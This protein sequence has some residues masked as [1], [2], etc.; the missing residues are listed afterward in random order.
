MKYV[1]FAFAWGMSCAG[2]SADGG[3]GLYLET[4]GVVVF[5]AENTASD[6][7]SWVKKTELEGFNGSGY[8]E[9]T[10]NQP[11][12]GPVSS[13]LEYE[14]KITKPGLYRLHIHCA[15]IMV[16]IRG[17]ERHD[18]ANDG[19][20]RVEGTYGDGPNAG[21]SHGDDALL[22]LLQSDTKF[23]GGKNEIFV[24]QSG[25]RLDPGGHQNK[26]VAVYDFKAGETYRFV[27]SGRSQFWKVDRIMFR[28]LDVPT[29]VAEQAGTA[30]SERELQENR[31]L[32]YA[33][34]HGLVGGG[35]AD[36]DEDGVSNFFEFSTGGDPM[37]KKDRGY[38]PRLVWSKD[39]GLYCQTTELAE[40]VRRGID[41][42][43]QTCS[44]LGVGQW[45]AVSESE[46]SR[47]SHPEKD[48]YEDVRYRVGVDGSSS[49]YRLIIKGRSG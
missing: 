40:Q 13:P 30:E 1:L 21:D 6:L 27:L 2:L 26:R 46:Q 25:R 15:R 35:S 48:G 44:E 29:E 24:W 19:Y 3:G 32:R 10:G 23:F 36:D 49:F 39:G 11:G 45:D 47:S 42:T 14:F 17:E 41:Y 4:D 38:A 20:V 16:V 37:D 31:F 5:E 12:S 7:G 9:F 43:V 18:V 33:A 22:S 34:D 8:L 28:H